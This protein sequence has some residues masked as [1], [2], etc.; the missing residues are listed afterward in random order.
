VQYTLQ[1]Y[2][3]AEEWPWLESMS[4]W[5]FRYPRPQQS[6]LDYFSFVT[7]DFVPKPIYEEVKRYAQG[8][9]VGPRF[10]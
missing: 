7:P 2:Q 1:A 5:A 3:L 9:D 4:L 8:D 10:E 6:Y